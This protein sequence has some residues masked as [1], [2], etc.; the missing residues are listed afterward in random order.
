MPRP[1]LGRDNETSLPRA[2]PTVLMSIKNGYFHV[3]FSTSG[4]LLEALVNEAH[5]EEARFYHFSH[6]G[7]K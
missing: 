1:G 3:K 6:L 4:F 7:T 5:W 2:T